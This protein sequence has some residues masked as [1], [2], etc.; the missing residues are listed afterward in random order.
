MALCQVLSGREQ[1]QIN[2][3]CQELF[4]DYFSLVV[5]C[6]ALPA[7]HAAIM[8][9]DLPWGSHSYNFLL[10]TYEVW[11]LSDFPLSYSIWSHFIVGVATQKSILPRGICAFHSPR[12]I[13]GCAY[14][15]C[16]QDFFSKLHFSFTHLSLHN[17]LIEPQWYIYIYI[18]IYIWHKKYI[19][20]IRSIW[21]SA[22]FFKRIN[23]LFSNFLPLL[24]LWV[25]LY[26]LWV[27]FLDRFRFVHITYV[28]MVEFYSRVQFLRITFHAKS[29][30]FSYF[31]I[32]TLR[33]SLIKWSTMSSM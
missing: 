2:L 21:L 12:H 27:I 32:P 6:N 18:Y 24:L 16:S 22:R 11:Y 20:G 28:R 29:C 7:D 33:N 10:I 8:E 15:V 1:R 25:V 13:L 17:K 19:Y 5:I 31:F 26:I 23:Y 3:I 30:L 4:T 14:T 9:F